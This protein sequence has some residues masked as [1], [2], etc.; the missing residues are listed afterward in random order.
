MAIRNF[1]NSRSITSNPLTRAAQLAIA[2]VLV[3]VLLA[4]SA[5]QT[6]AQAGGRMPLPSNVPPSIARLAETPLPYEGGGALEKAKSKAP[7]LRVL[8]VGNSFIHRNNMVAMLNELSNRDRS[9][10]NIFAVQFAPPESTLAQKV[11]SPAF[12]DLLHAVDWDVLVLQEQSKI[13]SFPDE[14]RRAQMDPAVRSLDEKIR[15]VGARTQLFMTW[16]YKDGDDVNVP[17]DTYEAMQLR[18][19]NGYTT[20]GREQHIPVVEIGLSWRDALR[21]QPDASLWDTDGVH[22]SALGSYYT[23]RLFYKALLEKNPPDITN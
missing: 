16:G 4:L 6:Q 21:E 7:G 1:M 14:Q 3:S 17:G 12:N 19:A 15:T 5:F 11:D 10:R 9:K 20:V 2:I 23:A 22:P 13:P 8:F 18:L